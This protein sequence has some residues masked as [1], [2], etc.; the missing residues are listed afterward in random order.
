MLDINVNNIVNNQQVQ[1]I[2]EDLQKRNP[3]DQSKNE[4]LLVD[5]ILQGNN[6]G[7]TGLTNISQKPSLEVKVPISEGYDFVGGEYLRKFPTYELGRDNAEFAAQNQSTGE[8]WANGALKFGTKTLSAVV[9]GTA[10]LV[11]GVEE[12]LT[13]GKFSSLYD[14]DFSNW[15]NDLD[16]KLNYQLPNYY[17]KQEQDLGLFGQMGTANFWSD[18]F[19]GGLS[20]TAGAL[21]SEGIW[22][23]ATGGTSLATS[24]ARLT[25]KLTRLASWSVRGAED[26]GQVLNGVSKYKAFLNSVPGQLYKAGTISKQTAIVAG[27][28]GDLISLSGKMARSAG[29]EASVE[30]LQ[31]KK[32]A[33]EKFY[34]N[35]ADLN[36]REPNTED[37]AQFEKDLEDRSNMVFK[38]NMAILIPSNA[39][40][41]G[42]VLGIKNPIK[43]G[44]ADFIDRKAFGYGLEKTAEGAFKT[45]ER[46]GLQKASRFTFNYVAKPAVT[47]GI[48]E[49][50]LQGVT[51]KYNSKWLEHTYDPKLSKETFDSIGAFNEAI[52]EQY[53]TKEGWV[54][55]GLGIL[56]GIVGGSVNARSQMKQ[57]AEELKYK[58]AMANTWQDKS[59][60]QIILPSKIQTANRIKGF[61]L[62]AKDEALKGNVAKS[63]LAKKSGQLAFINGEL[64]MGSSVKDITAKVE[65]SMET[66]TAEQ[67]AELGV[68]DIQQ[69]KENALAEINTLAKEWKTNKKYWQYVIGDKL[70]GEQN[71][72]FG[73]IDG[74]IG[75][76]GKNAS[77]VEA[78]AW[79]S[80][81]G[82][83]ANKIMEDVRISVSNEVGEEHAKTLDALKSIEEVADINAKQLK[84]LQNQ[85]KALKAKRT[86]LTN[87]ITKLDTLEVT[88]SQKAKRAEVTKALLET[89]EA[90]NGVSKEASDIADKINTFNANKQ[91]LRDF[92]HTTLDSN[93]SGTTISSDDILRLDENI[94]KFQSTLQSLELS[95]PQRAK[96]LNDLLEEYKQAKDIFLGAQATNRIV[97]SKDF[98]LENIGSYIGGKIA[99]NKAMDSTSQEWLQ[100]VLD[101]Y[102]KSMTS[103]LGQKEETQTEEAPKTA[104][105]I[106]KENEFSKAKSQEQIN[107]EKIDALEAER[108]QKLA[109]VEPVVVN[110]TSELSQKDLENKT[111]I[112][113]D[114][115]EVESYEINSNIGGGIGGIDVVFKGRSD[116]GVITT[117]EY[118]A[119][120]KS[121]IVD[122][123]GKV[124]EV[125]TEK[126]A[127]I[128]KQQ[129]SNQSDIEAKKADIERRRQEEVEP[130]TKEIEK[131]EKEIE[132]IE[133]DDKTQGAYD[134][135]ASSNSGKWNS[136][137][138]E[139]LSLVQDN[140]KA[141]AIYKFLIGDMETFKEIV[142]YLNERGIEIPYTD[143][144]KRADETMTVE[145]RK[146]TINSYNNSVDSK[147]EDKTQVEKDILSENNLQD[148]T[149]Y[150][151][152]EL[153][154]KYP[155]TGVQKVIWNL[156]K[157]IV[158]K[159]GIKVKFSSSRITEG[160][161][162]SNN[163]QNGEILIRPSTLKNGRFGEVL[164]HEVVHALTTKIISRVNSGVTT[165]LTQKQIN[166]VKGLM[167]LFEAVKA[168]N[169][170]ENKYP[171]KDVFEFIAHLTNETFVK[172][173][174]S[175]DKNFLQK[176]VDFILDIFGITNANELSKKYLLD[177]ISDG[178]FLQEN[179][180]TVLP[181][182]YGNNLQRSKND[183]KLQQLKDKLQELKG[184]LSKIN[185][186]YDAELKAL[187]EQPTQIQ[188]K[189]TTKTTPNQVEIDKIN[190]EYDAKINALKPKSQNPLEQYKQRLETLLK[191]RYK[192][193]ISVEDETK[194]TQEEIQT[195]K[196]GKADDELKAKLSR[197]KL[198]DA[199]IDEDGVSVADLITWINQ[200]E[201]TIE[202]EDTKDEIE[203]EDVEQIKDDLEGTNITDDY[204]LAQNTNG[205]ATIV[206][207]K[208]SNKY[209]LA[210]I[211]MQTLIDRLGGEFKVL[212]S[213]QVKDI[214]LDKLKPND[215][216]EVDG[217]TL[218]YLSGGQIEINQ[219]DFLSRQQSLNLYIY[220][221]GL[222]WSYKN[223]YE[224]KGNEFVKKA[225]DFAENE[226]NSEAIYDQK[227]GD[228]LTLEI[229][230]V[231]G[232]NST[233]FGGTKEQLKIYLVD[234]KG[235]KISTLKAFR[236]GKLDQD[237]AVIREEAFKRWEE[238]GRPSK[239]KLGIQVETENIFFGSPEIIMSENGTPTNIPITE[240]G[241]SQVVAT[242][243]IENGE[244][245]LNREIK[246]VSTVFVN[247]LS[248]NTSK[249]VPLVVIKK[250]AYSIAYPIS[251]VK[252]ATPQTDLFDG[253]LQ[254][255]ISPQEKVLKINEAIINQNIK[256]DRLAFDD[257]NNQEKLDGVRKAFEDKKVF[258]D[259]KTLAD[260]NYK[261]KNLVND[262][263]INIDLENLDQAIS[264]AKLRVSYKNTEIKITLD[265]KNN[266]LSEVETE[267]SNLTFE[268]AQDYA[269][270]A[271]TKYL[272]SKGD[273]IEDTAYTNAFD[274]NEVTKAESHLDK[275]HN[276]KVLK[277]ALSEKLSKSLEKA[278]GTDKIRQ[279]ESLIKQYDFLKKQIVVSEEELKE[280]LINTD[281]R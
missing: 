222:N 11:Y 144:M 84:I 161:D 280:G 131:V 250:G 165:G 32:E 272:D 49:E 170:L 164:V 160:F 14:N 275:M 167:K 96:Y 228:K 163:P 156:I 26:V 179:G 276:I 187:E 244:I 145:E 62:D 117:E 266:N 65:K 212:R 31:F 75:N 203:V 50:G 240:A 70:V 139:L 72:T 114:G 273:I 97:S 225:S 115:Q 132:K 200:E 55:N 247:K 60:Q 271:D 22:A 1:P 154:E 241:V 227:Q 18:K 211:K 268:L 239:M 54:E 274:D 182:D 259:A 19:L 269:N 104:E 134:F 151:L 121:Y 234:S 192:D 120:R 101:D 59:L 5:K 42:N 30:A 80:T 190:K 236:E 21:V 155:L 204:T 98:K 216:V 261:I 129:I 263:Q 51:T 93:F 108:R 44:L 140:R 2:I 8:K 246:D 109:E 243:F 88:D 149:E 86:R 110:Q 214:K 23:W 232:F 103:Q 56:I 99:K 218:T 111:P 175:K 152:Q 13:D 217:M 255:T 254:S 209:R 159:L 265:D 34:S 16:T 92:S 183:T 262:A 174:E 119:L 20:F 260:K 125:G 177:I 148:E 213:N 45:I 4:P 69:Y 253:I 95:N 57:D 169:N 82:E 58:E 249:K 46:T 172:E 193:L 127:P 142:D 78:L 105:E 47:E 252:T 67:W 94:A 25:P 171:V 48:G 74:V 207:P 12:A 106:K 264:D 53:G 210:H 150:T 10:G 64:V 198:Y 281:C 61:A 197:W 188:Q 215:V 68:E 267:L 37:I 180:V 90:I 162:G 81:I 73:A 176:V 233:A 242:G 143:R 229:D 15:M 118:N 221:S 17:T 6:F 33:E 186:K 206:K 41:M 219:D 100:S 185:A 28:A 256:T 76:F 85:N 230:D 191:T 7:G 135:S 130:I 3:I 248:K 89:E 173:L 245:S 87:Q 91:G 189:P 79:Q 63:E 196:D 195:F 77:I 29:Y 102:S 123:D 237:F 138:N 224:V 238:Q 35:F 133:K 279:V 277:Q 27:Q 153:I 184:Q 251:M 122:K 107:Q 178:V 158:N 166:A 201:T 39:I 157:D 208:N 66:V 52:S 278:I 223:L 257:I 36:G 116:V 141:F 126:Q 24:M 181:S 38:T 137:N 113:I 9:G 258:V 40:M 205:S 124:Y 199:S 83:N 128:Q 231:D 146:S 270:N 202:V 147:I 112:I 136:A 220:N 235:R 194:P 168:D 43:T 226:V 71:L